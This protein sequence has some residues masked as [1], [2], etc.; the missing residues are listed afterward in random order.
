MLNRCV[1][2]K[3]TRGLPLQQKMSDLP[4]ERTEPTPPFTHVGVDLFEPFVVKDR[5]TE[6]KRWGVIF[7]CLYS[8]AIHLELIDDL[9]TDSFINTLR[10]FQ[11]IRG[12]VRTLFCDQGTNF[13]GTKNKLD[14]EMKEIDNENLRN[15]ILENKLEFKFNTPSASHRGGIWERQIRTVRSILN[16]ILNKYHGRLDTSTLRTTLYETMAIVNSRPLTADTLSSPD[17]A[18]VTPNHLLTGKPQQL[19]PP[20][21]NFTSTEVY[22][23]ERWR[24]TQQIA[25]EFWKDWSLHYLSNITKRQRWEQRSEEIK[26][27]DVVLVMEEST[28]RSQW[29]TGIV[30]EV[31]QSK[32]G[33]AR[34]ARIRMATAKLNKKGVLTEPPTFLERPVQKLVPIMTP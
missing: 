34:T 13:I 8:R 33:L 18:I 32:D 29:R 3:S 31:L 5:R 20:P 11:A 19:V 23:K 10:C 27:G 15:Y 24:K 4:K 28:I 7:T 26:V 25:E 21:G 6:I 30:E 16:N 9:S 17:V 2:C 14:K 22:G 1:V 12:P